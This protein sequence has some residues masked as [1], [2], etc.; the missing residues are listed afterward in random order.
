MNAVSYGAVFVI[1]FWFMRKYQSHF[2]TTLLPSLFV[3]I[4]FK[5]TIG[6]LGFPWPLLCHSQYANLGLI[7]IASITGCWGVT[8]LI[9]QINETLAHLFE[10]GFRPKILPIAI[11]PIVLVGIYGLWGA[12][13]LAKKVPEGNIEATIVQGS[14]STNVQWTNAFN[15]QE[16]DEYTDL[17]IDELSRNIELNDS[18][19]GKAINRLVIWPETAVPDAVRSRMSL[20]RILALASNYDATFLVGCLTDGPGESKPLDLATAWKTR[21]SYHEY[22]SIVAFE[23]D[24]KVVPVYSKFHLVP[25]GEVIPLSKLITKWFPEYPWGSEDVSAG[26]GFHVADTQVGK[27]GAVV[28]Y[29]SFFPQIF[30]GEVEKGAQIMVLGSNTSWFGRSMASY[31]HARF[32]VYRAVE[33]G[34]WFCRAAT[35]GVSSIIDP[36]GHIIVETELFKARA[37]TA[38][39]GLRSGETLYTILGDWLP[40][41]CGIYFLVLM[42]G[43]FL[44]KE[45]HSE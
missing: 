39:V 6:F 28:C 11:M 13:S 26:T 20:T 21:D 10:G 45:N 43:V 22:N 4:E 5:Q 19:E 15:R 35:T 3:L 34:I 30:R 29:E 40:G 33:N 17:T 18:E 41:L 27:I 36:Q 42:L 1:Y 44:L 38:R 37:V 25:F 32:D 8:F 31:Q 24:G 7:Q 12:L 2:Y 23:P 14:E 16:I 9:V